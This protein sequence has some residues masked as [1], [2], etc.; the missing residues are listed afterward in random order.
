MI[1]GL[2]FYLVQFFIYSETQEQIYLVAST[3]C[4]A[5]YSER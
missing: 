3:I 4:L 5:Q 2:Q 1:T